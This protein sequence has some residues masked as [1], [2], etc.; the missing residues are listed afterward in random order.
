MQPEFLW[1]KFPDYAV[2]RHIDNRK[3][4]GII[5]NIPR[6]KLMFEGADEVD[7][8]DIKVDPKLVNTLLDEPGFLPAYHMHRGNW[9]TILL[10]GT[11]PLAR[12]CELIDQSYQITGPRPKRQ[13]S[14]Q[15]EPCN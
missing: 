4:F 15:E 10:D 7:I 3:W 5:M 6:H 9:V 12:I 14:R 2:F 13:P 8:L 11:C 1:T